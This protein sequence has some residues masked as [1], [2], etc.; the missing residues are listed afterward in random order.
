MNFQFICWI[1]NLSLHSCVSFAQVS[2]NNRS[3]PMKFVPLSLTIWCMLPRRQEHL[4]SAARK[5]S[6]D[7]LVVI[8]KCTA[9][10]TWQTNTTIHA[11]MVLS[12]RSGLALIEKGP[13][14]S[15][16]TVA[17]GCAG[18]TRDSGSWLISGWITCWLHRT[19]TMQFLMHFFIR[20]LMAGIQNS[21]FRIRWTREFPACRFDMC[22]NVTK[23]STS[24]GSRLEVHCSN[25]RTILMMN[26][27]L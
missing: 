5:C 19:H 21:S 8:S 18:V 4:L 13:H 2:F 7:K 12:N 27:S 20:S 24:F 25:G 23:R 3:L 16:P 11:L 1:A 14:R 10:V 22:V 9:L 26:I 17:K 15:R 6:V